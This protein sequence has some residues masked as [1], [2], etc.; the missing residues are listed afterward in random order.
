MAQ[1]THLPGDDGDEEEEADE[2]PQMNI[3]LAPKTMYLRTDDASPCFQCV[4]LFND[5][6]ICQEGR[7]LRE[8]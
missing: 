5:D 7:Y 8:R 2:E 1:A 3:F 4:Q 6:D